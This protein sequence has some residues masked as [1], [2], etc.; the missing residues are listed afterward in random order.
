M[1]KRLLL[2]TIMS[3]ALLLS[4]RMPALAAVPAVTQTFNLN[5]G[6]N[7]VYLEV[8]PQSSTPADVFKDLPAGSS[9]WAWTGKNETIAQFIQD[10]G[11][12]PVVNAKW[13]AIFASSAES[14]LNNLYAIKA[15]SA[16]LIHVP[17]GTPP[18]TMNITGRPTIR[19]KSWIPDSFN[20]AGFGFA[21]SPPTF[22]NFFAPSNSHKNQAIYRL[23]N[24]SGAWEIVS[25][26]ATTVMRS[27]EAFW[28]Y[29]QSGSDYQGPLGVEA[30]GADGLDFGAGITILTLTVKNDSATDKS[31]AVSQ[32]GAANP[33]SLAYRTYDSTS[34]KILTNQLSGMPAIAVK[35]GGSTVITLVA[36]RGSFSG[37]GASV[38]EFTDTQGNRVRVPVT[39]VSN[40]VNGYPGLWSGVASLNKVSQLSD[41]S[42]TA[43]FT[44]GQPKTTPAELNLNLIL[45]QSVNGQVRLLKQAVVMFQDGTVS[46]DGSPLTKGRYVVLTKD[47]LIPNFSGVSQRDGAK[48]GRR[49]SAIGF[50]YSPSS[51]ATFGTDFDGT[52]LKCSG[53]ISTVIE[54]R[55]ILESSA[56]D[57]NPTNPFLHR[58]H[59]DHDNLA[60][61]YKAFRPEA[62]RISRAITLA[63]DSV[64]KDNPT[65][66]PP[67]WGISILGGTYRESVVGLAKGAIITEGNFT[68]RLATDVGELNQ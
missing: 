7:A 1:N 33:V 63:F 56:A 11:E 64:P 31:V 57:T 24:T 60:S 68:I 35:A 67:G 42:P 37:E 52:A 16:Y 5:P 49:L 40:P 26:P 39:A 22:A 17:A 38:L 48:V 18:L 29:C 15:N 12:A 9:V 28:I 43:P 20:L 45:H 50:D 27:G 62:N 34:G 8:Q 30:E 53:T 4:I 51:D 61:D 23:N 65:N 46:A 32:A 14:A 55:P 19:H 13:L 25:N 36:Q 21:S 66:P 2:L 47:S 54:C 59:P 44:A 58:Y 6:W 3:L 41:S 10:P